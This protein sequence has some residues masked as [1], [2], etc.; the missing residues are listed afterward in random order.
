M[1]EKLIDNYFVRK[2]IERIEEDL[3]FYRIDSKFEIDKNYLKLYI[4][5]K[6][7]KD[8][9]YKNVITISKKTCF[10]IICDNSEY[11]EL[12]KC[13]DSAIQIINEGKY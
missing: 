9:Y 1:I 4:K 11:K 6:K 5:N 8:Q 7:L 12:Y 3:R 2:L 10:K 13:I